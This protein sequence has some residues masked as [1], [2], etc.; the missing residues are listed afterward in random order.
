MRTAAPAAANSGAVSTPV[1]R[2]GLASIGLVAGCRLTGRHLRIL[3]VKQVWLPAWQPAP[4]RRRPCPQLPNPER[5]TD[6]DRHQVPHLVRRPAGVLW[7]HQQDLV[8]PLRST[9]ERPAGW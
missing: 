9:V 7:R 4:D 6:A 3:A 1:D 5:L 2:V 8:T